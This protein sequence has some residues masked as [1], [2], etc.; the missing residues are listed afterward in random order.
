[1]HPPTQVRSRMRSVAGVKVGDKRR[2]LAANTDQI[3]VTQGRM[4]GVAPTHKTV[5]ATELISDQVRVQAII[6]G[7]LKRNAHRLAGRHP[8]DLALEP[9]VIRELAL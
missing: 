3:D 1:M 6:F 5:I 2:L 9:Q 7:I 8:G 4:S